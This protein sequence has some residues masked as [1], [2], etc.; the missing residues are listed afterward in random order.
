[1]IEQMVACPC[2]NDYGIE[3]A[4]RYVSVLAE[5]FVSR[6]RQLLIAVH[7]MICATDESSF[8]SRANPV[9]AS[10]KVPKRSRIDDREISVYLDG[11]VERKGS[12]IIKHRRGDDQF[13]VNVA[14]TRD[15]AAFHRRTVGNETHER[16]AEM[17]DED[18]SY[19][20]HGTLCLWLDAG[21]VKLHLPLL[22]ETGPRLMTMLDGANVGDEGR[23]TAIA[24]V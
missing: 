8:R 22:L 13:E 16:L 24:R 21:Y 11:N 7:D 19:S 3:A 1:M 4:Q 15:V 10:L 12:N 5:L 6:K 9:Y 23:F 2:A 17:G 18:A 14:A 20:L